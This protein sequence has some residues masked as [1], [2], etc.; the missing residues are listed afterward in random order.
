MARQRRR[1]SATT[2]APYRIEVQ[3]CLDLEFSAWLGGMEIVA[4]SDSQTTTLTGV[5][6]DQTA[7][8]GVLESLHNLQIALIRVERLDSS[9][10]APDRP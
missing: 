9:L 4:D 7:L 2:P 8:Q 3:G 1:I 6:P 10:D 5:L